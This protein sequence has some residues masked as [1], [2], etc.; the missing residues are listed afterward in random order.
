MVGVVKYE[1]RDFCK[2]TYDTMQEMDGVFV[3]SFFA[4][5]LDV[6]PEFNF[7]TFFISFVQVTHCS[8]AP[9]IV[10]LPIH[11]FDVIVIRDTVAKTCL[12]GSFK[13][14]LIEPFN[15]HGCINLARSEINPDNY[16]VVRN[17]LC[18]NIGKESFYKRRLPGAFSAY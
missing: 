16:S 14:M 15:Y 6:L 10:F 4:A 17:S 2:T 5:M 1:A 12:L 8:F 13:E 18:K 7:E 3:R 11:V 9:T